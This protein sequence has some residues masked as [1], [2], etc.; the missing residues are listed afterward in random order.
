MR[1][2]FA[3]IPIGDTAYD[4]QKIRLALRTRHIYL[5]FVMRNTKNGSGL[6]RWRWDVERTFA[7]MNSSVM[8]ACG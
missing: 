8:S 1:R 5:S 2:V 3:L 6:G 4:A 7:W